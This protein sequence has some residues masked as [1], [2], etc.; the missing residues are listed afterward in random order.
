MY[1]INK[2]VL[3]F[4]NP[5]TFGM[6][7]M[8]AGIVLVSGFRLQIASC[9]FQVSGFRRKLGVWLIVGAMGW[10][11]VWSMGVTQRLMGW[12]FGLDRYRVVDVGTLPKADYIVDLGGGMGL[13]TNVCAYPYLSGAADRVW[14]SARL[15][16]AGKAPFVIPTGI[17]IVDTDAVFLKDLGVPSS[18]ILVENQARNTEENAIFTAALIAR[19]QRSRPLNIQISR[20]CVLLVTSVSH[21][22]RALMIFKKKSPRLECV[23]VVTDCGSV[24][25]YNLWSWNDFIPQI[26]GFF[27]NLIVYKECLGIL[28][29]KLRGF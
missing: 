5:L 6:A 3:A 27:G 19:H 17:G 7:L 14:H 25:F 11:C 23:P 28:G 16:K 21:M 1:Y 4:V 29:Y 2:I 8:V 22:R 12:A 10:F 9:K 15:W 13:N 26:G 20:P 18:A 24:N